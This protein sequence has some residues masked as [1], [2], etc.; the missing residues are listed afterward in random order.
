MAHW[1]QHLLLCWKEES[2]WIRTKLDWRDGWCGALSG[3]ELSKMKFSQ[4]FPKSRDGFSSGCWNSRGMQWMGWGVMQ[5]LR[6]WSF[7]I[8]K[9]KEDGQRWPKMARFLR[10]K[11]DDG[12]LGKF[13]SADMGEE[14]EWLAWE[15][16]ET[17]V[18]QTVR[19][20]GRWGSKKIENPWVFE[21]HRKLGSRK[22][23]I[24]ARVDYKWL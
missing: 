4:E 8:S 23:P 10:S 21:K 13:I 18:H 5:L 17:Q 12:A 9:V 11:W 6:W 7:K 15:T 1:C 20:L 19:V 3:P 2:Y 24:F 14:I 16:T 22:G